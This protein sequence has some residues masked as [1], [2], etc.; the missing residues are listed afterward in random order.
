MFEEKLAFD[1]VTE[2]ASLANLL[3]PLIRQNYVF[4]FHISFFNI[5]LSLPPI[6]L[7]SS[8]IGCFNAVMSLKVQRKRTTISL[9]FLMGDICINSQRGVPFKNIYVSL[10]KYLVKLTIF[11]V[12]Q[13]FKLNLI[14]TFQGFINPSQNYSH[15][16][17]AYY[18]DY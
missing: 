1:R 16:T 6:S 2:R 17:L 14:Q 8:S 12:Q 10:Q 3:N 13:N 9:S 7:D 11:F 4:T 18:L 15:V 5:F